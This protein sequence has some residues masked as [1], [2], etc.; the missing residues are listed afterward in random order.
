MN[1]HHTLAVAFVAA[2]AVPV[3]LAGSASASGGGGGVVERSGSCSGSTD[4]KLKAKPDDGRLEVEGEIDSNRNG[5]TWNWVIRHND[6]VAAQG[7]ARTTAPSGSFEV[8]RTFANL[9]GVD[10]FVFRATNPASGEVCRG[11]VRI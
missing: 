4:W 1:K 11:V 8:Q 9:A 7:Q 10:T 5:Q 6:S 3:A 2:L